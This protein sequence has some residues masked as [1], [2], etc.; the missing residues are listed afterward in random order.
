M[1]SKTLKKLIIFPILF[2]LLISLTS[3]Q[4][5]SGTSLNPHNHSDI[6]SGEKEASVD[7]LGYAWYVTETGTGTDCTKTNPGPLEY[8]VETKAQSGDSVYVGEGTYTS[9]DFDDYL[10]YIQK[11]IKLIGSCTWTPSSAPIC[12]PQDLPPSTHTSYLNGENARRVIAV[13][14]PDISVEIKNFYIFQGNAD[15]KS[16]KPAGILG[17]GGGIYA[18]DVSSLTIANNYIWQNKASDSGTLSTDYGYGGGMYVNNVNDL[19]VLENTFIFN[20]ASSAASTGRGGGLYVT[21]CGVDGTTTIESNRIHENMVGDGTTDSTGAGAYLLYISNLVLEDNIF[22]Y[23][24]TI[25]SYWTPGSALVFSH[26]EANSIDHNVFSDNY[27]S[28]IVYFNDLNGDITRNTFWDNRAAYDLKIQNANEIQIMNNFFGKWYPRTSPLSITDNEIRGGISTIIYIATG[29]GDPRVDIIHN[30]F[31][32]AEYGVQIDDLLDVLVERNI[33][34]GFT[35][36]AVD[37]M[38]PA[39]TNAVIN[40]NLF[41]DNVDNGDTGTT[42]WVADP[43]LVDLNHG[44]FHL[45]AGSEAINKVPIGTIFNDIDDQPRPMGFWIDLGADEFTDDPPVYL[46]FIVR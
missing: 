22:E 25:H 13:M 16:P 38:N 14:G 1:L 46:P 6:S 33:F 7:G 18:D 21:Q 19:N 30:T 20:T 39:N 15:N 23:H 27:G 4:P 9:T 44:D 29:C 40:E 36:K 43:M 42:Y 26:V 5:A 2:I 8:C 28:S 11:S 17:A 45:Q 12:Y 3:T 34:I 37:V 24:N 10:L 32:L 35:K 31:G 41:Y